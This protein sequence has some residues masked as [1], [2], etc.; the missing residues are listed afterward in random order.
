MNRCR[1]NFVFYKKQAVKRLLA[2]CVFMLML[3]AGTCFSAYL[4]IKA[5]SFPYVFDNLQNIDSIPIRKIMV[6]GALVYKDGTVSPLLKQRLDKAKAAYDYLQQLDRQKQGQYFLSRDSVVGKNKQA[7][8]IKSLQIILSGSKDGG[9]DEPEA[10][11][12]YLKAQGISA[13]I[14]LLDKSGINT[15]Y[16]C[17]NY[18]AKYDTEQ[19]LIVTSDYHLERSCYLARNLGL[20]AYGLAANSRNF[21][22]RTQTYN[23]LREALSRIKAIINVY[24]SPNFAN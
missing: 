12:N 14:L 1:I 15:Y 8:K 22:W 6:L 13:K 16:S 20:Q 3:G 11:A 2:F 5:Y 9:Y 24:I 19:V 7:K 4:L 17:L 10:M 23:F 18:R 21:S